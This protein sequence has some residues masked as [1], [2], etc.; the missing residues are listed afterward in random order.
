MGRG[1]P[2]LIKGMSYARDILDSLEI[3]YK[4]F[5]YDSSM[6]EVVQYA[7]DLDDWY[8]KN[9]NITDFKIM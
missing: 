2:R 9:K 1:G 5:G 4:F 7:V 6:V 8:R 3:P